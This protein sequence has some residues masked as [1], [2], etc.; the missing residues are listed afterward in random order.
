MS[1]GVLLADLAI[2][3]VLAALVLIVAPGSCGR[4]DDRAGR[5]RCVR[6]ELRARC[7]ARALMER[8]PAYG[9]R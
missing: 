8:A 1:R 4:G 6:G 9:G 5:D 7:A 2:A 3:V